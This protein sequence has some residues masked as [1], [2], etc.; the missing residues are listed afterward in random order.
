MNLF[1][2]E[3]RVDSDLLNLAMLAYWSVVEVCFQDTYEV[4]SLHPRHPWVSKA[5]VEVVHA[6]DPNHH[7]HTLAD[8]ICDHYFLV[9][10]YQLANCQ[11]RSDPDFLAA[12]SLQVSVAPSLKGLQDWDTL[13]LVLTLVVALAWALDFLAKP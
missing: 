3:Q 12:P 11:V 9:Y 1:R 2:T 8:L 13:A 6:E 4:L 5:P 7:R 10:R